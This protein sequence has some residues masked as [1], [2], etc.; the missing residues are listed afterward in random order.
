M[1]G[2][3]D[4]IGGLLHR[5]AVLHPERAALIELGAGGQ[6]L[7]RTTFRDLLLSAL[8]ISAELVALGAQ[9][10]AVLLQCDQGAEFIAGFFGCLYA[11]A[12]A[13]PTPIQRRG[14]GRRRSDGI[15]AEVNP[16][17]V[18][19][20]RA[21]EAS[22]EGFMPGTP[23]VR[24]DLSETVGDLVCPGPLKGPA[25]I[26]YTSGSTINPKGVIVSHESLAA[27]LEMISIS[28]KTGPE[29]I[30]LSWLPLFHDMGLVGGP[31]HS[32]FIGAPLILIQPDAFFRRPELWLEAITRYR[33]TWSGG[34]DFA[35]SHCVSASGRMKL[36]GLDLRCWETAFCGSEKVRASTMRAFADTFAP[37]GF[38]AGS[39][40]PCYGLAEA[41]LYASGTYGIR[42][43][44]RGDRPVVC[45]G[46]PAP[47][48]KVAIVDPETGRRTTGPNAGEIWISGAHVASGYYGRP[49]E[50]AN[51]FKAE[52]EP[53]E[54]ETFL[55]TGDL[56]FVVDGELYVTGR[57][58]DAI[59]IRGEN[60]HPEDIEATIAELRHG[61]RCVAFGVDV[62]AQEEVI[63]ALEAGRSA[64]EQET[65][66]AV[67]RSIRSDV[68]LAHGV[69]PYDVVVVRRNTIPVTTSGKV[70]REQCRRLYETGELDV[71][72]GLRVRPKNS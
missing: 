43:L 19:L 11:G 55:K 12:F 37:F 39:L 42:V 27:N 57:L 33:V 25:F 60:I 22:I 21:T 40:Y 58:K 66:H 5:W 67:A 31:L 72:S 48:S 45:C 7:R 62:D 24:A 17:A 52:P 32:I 9:G 59:I 18:I 53:G 63:V 34:P 41:T 23:R 56:G 65:W 70:R 2:A 30:A 3:G 46:R 61:T 6:E 35:F 38:R 71:I 51:T 50:T 28:M 64:V 44:P 4:D 16:A 14:R 68:A 10:Q 8:H 54:G 26:Q 49:D 15:V 13:V 1:T 69:A 36:D 47:G 20:S 29:T